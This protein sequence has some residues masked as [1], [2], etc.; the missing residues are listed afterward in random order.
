M[1]VTLLGTGAPLHPD[2][3]MTGMI[4]TAPHCAPLLIDTCG[5][6]ELARQLNLVGFNRAEIRAVVVTHRHLD[7]AGGIQD[8]FLARIPLDIYAL[9]DT[10]EGIAE[11]TKG[12]FPEWELH[13][14]I[15][16]HEIWPGVAR[17]IAGFQ[18]K[19]FTATHRVPTVAVRV[20]VGGKTFAFSADTMACDEIVACANNADLFLC[21]TLCA[22]LDG[23][24]A[25]VSAWSAMHATARDAA[26]MATLA[27]AG[28]LACTHIARFANPN[29]I[30]AEATAN[31]SGTAT[32]ANDGDRYC[33]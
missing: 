15:A 4:I 26:A 16:R 29:N 23:E 20:S 8:L 24:A 6:L 10:H 3:A 27:G 30:L 28:A 7:H 12:S 25:T 14:D 22:D 31:F 13:P 18:V 32:V 19:F 9:Q 1:E 11:V 17:E 21:D 2:R 5:G 33:I